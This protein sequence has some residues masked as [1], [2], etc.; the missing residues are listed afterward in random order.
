MRRLLHQESGATM[1][2]Y[3]LMV[4]FVVIVAFLAVQQFGRSVRELFDGAV[5]LFP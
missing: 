3:S 2:E 4:P 1:V 5:S